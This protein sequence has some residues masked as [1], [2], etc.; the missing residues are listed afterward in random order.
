MHHLQCQLVLR[1]RNKTYKHCTSLLSRRIRNPRRHPQYLNYEF[2]NESQ[3]QIGAA[4]LS[5][6]ATKLLHREE[7]S[8]SSLKVPIHFLEET[9][10]TNVD[11]KTANELPVTDR[12]ISVEPFVSDL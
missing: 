3:I 7:S 9:T 2:F 10:S 4:V 5:S 1:T 8:T 12:M 11:L 6:V